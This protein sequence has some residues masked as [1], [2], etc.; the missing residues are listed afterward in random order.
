MK[1]L[2][3]MVAVVVLTLSQGAA[4]AMEQSEHDAQMSL[5]R[6][7]A[8]SVLCI[9]KDQKKASG[10]RQASLMQGF[11]N[12]VDI[13]WIAQFVLGNSWR[14]ATEEQRARYTKL[15]RNYLTNV[16]VST[17]AESP[18]KKI[19]DIKILGVVD[20]ANDR[21]SV[22]TNIA[23]SNADSIRVDY[24]VARKGDGYKIIDVSIE[25]VSLLSTHRAE[26]GR[27]AGVGGIDSVIKALENQGNPQQLASSGSRI[28]GIN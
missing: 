24:L 15:Y 22:R 9:I 7:M 4:F 10:D 26:F 19:T 17:Y 12:V 18:D 21:F 5:A 6:D 13:D 2:T 14:N 23:L 8:N 16:Y 27:I 11:A 3:R 20:A 28:G 1:F 25:G